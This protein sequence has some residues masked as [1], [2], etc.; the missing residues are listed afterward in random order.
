M[1]NAPTIFQKRIVIAAAACVAAFALVGIRLVDVTLL[2]GAISGHRAHFAA[3]ETGRAD[4]RDR[5]GI[6]LARDLPVTDIG[7]RPEYF[8][9][10]KQAAHDLAHATGAN[11]AHLAAMFQKKPYVLVA[12]RVTP[13]V[14]DAVMA[15]G[16][17]ALDLMPQRKRYYPMGREAAQAIG[18][19]EPDGSGVSGLEL[20]LD[21]KL[22]DSK[23][24]IVTSLDA[25]VQFILSSEL[26]TARQAYDAH[27]VGGIVMNVNTGE[28]LA[29]A[30]LPDF[31]PNARSGSEGDSTRNIMAQDA[32]EL[33]SVFKIFAFTLAMEDHTTRLDETFPIA[34]GFH[35]GNHTIHDA[36]HLPSVMMAKDILAQS[37]NVGTAQI[38]LRSGPTRQRQ[39]LQNMGLL[40][41][42]VTELPE[43]RKPMYPSNWGLTETAT[44]GFGHGISVSPLSFVAAAAT[45][46]NGGRK[47]V[48]TFLK[49]PVDSRGAQLIKPETS[50]QMRDLLRYVVTNGTGKNADV[51]G[52][53][54]GGKT[55]SAEKNSGGHY[56]AHKLLTSFCAVFPVHDPRYIVFVMIDEPHGDKASGVMALAGHTAAP[57]AG[58]VVSRIAP[59]LGVPRAPIVVADTHK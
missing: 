59:L 1:S 27:A 26:A 19:T 25:R 10:K 50:A 42:I 21:K 11:E 49:N 39:F 48:P 14:L 34:A 54:V 29:M 33:G 43:R 53:D 47:I 51:P 41:A 17:P 55:G 6:I 7:A 38:A 16:L 32:Y 4:L 13:D 58:H 36:E 52:Y 28:V 24:P 35:I 12:Q 46:V 45:V 18:V 22:K 31:D 8:W 40:D 5:N 20:G 23:A 15:L 56:V 9:D 30:S 37:S 2:N 44:I 57:V 3:R